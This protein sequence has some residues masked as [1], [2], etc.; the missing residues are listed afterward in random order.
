MLFTGPHAQDLA[1]L[2]TLQMHVMR[3]VFLLRRKPDEAWVEYNQRSMRFVRVWMHAN[4]CAR[5]STTVRELQFGIA[6]HWCRQA[7]DDGRGVGAKPG[8]PA[9]F[10]RW[11]NLKWWRGQQR[12]SS[13]ADGLR[14]PG[15]FFPASFERELAETLGCDWM[16]KGED[17]AAW[18]E[19]REL[20]LRQTDQPW[21][22]GRQLALVHG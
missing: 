18:A 21:C 9:R 10:L 6:G 4:G 20:W 14:H 15:H 2:N 1:A 7:K 22:R 16:K 5:W 17:R 3:D 19:L 12:I 8:L 13:A 11:R